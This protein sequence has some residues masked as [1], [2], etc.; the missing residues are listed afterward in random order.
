MR[1]DGFG[2]L[3]SKVQGFGFSSGFRI[4]GVGLGRRVQKYFQHV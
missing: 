3:G 1:I 4:Q 2:G